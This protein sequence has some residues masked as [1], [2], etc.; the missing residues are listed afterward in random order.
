ML[1]LRNTDMAKWIMH[2]LILRD[3]SL[4]DRIVLV[5]VCIWVSNSLCEYLHCAAVGALGL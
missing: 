2:I 1:T 5:P 4:D 3:F